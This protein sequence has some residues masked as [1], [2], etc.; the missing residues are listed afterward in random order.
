MLANGT[1]FA[2]ESDSGLGGSLASVH[3]VEIRGTPGSVEAGRLIPWYRPEL[4]QGTS[5]AS[6]EPGRMRPAS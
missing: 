3:G 1:V 2:L 6:M 4:I 5:Q